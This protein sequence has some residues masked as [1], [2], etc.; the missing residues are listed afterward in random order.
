MNR[1]DDSL[2]PT[3][4]MRRSS[5]M[6]CRM[7]E[8]AKF[9]S[10]LLLQSGCQIAHGPT[11]VFPDHD[12]AAPFVAD[13]FCERRSSSPVLVWM[14]EPDAAFPFSSTSTQRPPM[15]LPVLAGT[16]TMCLS[17]LLHCACLR[18]RHRFQIKIQLCCLIRLVFVFVIDALTAPFTNN[19]TR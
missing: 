5:K 9:P 15:W 14:A 12:G 3:G 18:R 16:Q 8:K 11:D 13:E 10:R 4:K 6:I 17:F 7:R 1:Y 2:I 19:E